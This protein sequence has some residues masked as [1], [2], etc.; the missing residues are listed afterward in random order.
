MEKRKKLVLKELDREK[1]A[2]DLRPYVE[3]GHDDDARSV[4]SAVSAGG[5][6]DPEMQVTEYSAGRKGGGLSTGGHPLVHDIEDL[7]QLTAGVTRLLKTLNDKVTQLEL[8]EKMVRVE[9]E[10]LRKEREE[11]KRWKEEL[12][13]QREGGSEF[14]RFSD[15]AFSPWTRA[16]LHSRKGTSKA[17][18]LLCI[19]V[20]QSSH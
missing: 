2:V 15:G 8:D 1:G 12:E 14:V 10:E 6:E 9:R 13:G 4:R 19:W 18:P 17:C 16:S 7:K 20:V 11:V 5:S 3:A